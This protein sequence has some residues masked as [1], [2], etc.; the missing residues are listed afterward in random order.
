MSYV[1]HSSVAELPDPVR[2]SLDST[3]VIGTEMPSIVRL[4]QTGQLR[5]APNGGWQ[6]FTATQE[7]TLDPPGFVWRSKLK[8]GGLPLAKAT[9]SLIDGKGSMQVRVMGMITVVDEQGPEMDQG[10]VLRWFNETMWF[11]SIW[12]SPAIAWEQIDSRSAAGS[13]TV[14]DVKVTA[15][16]RFDEVGRLVDF[17][18]DRY[19]TVGD[20]FE[21]T[22]W[23]TPL[24]DH[25]RLAGLVLPAAGSGCPGRADGA[26]DD[27]GV[28]SPARRR[29]ARCDPRARFRARDQSG[30]GD[31]GRLHLRGSAVG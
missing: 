6:K 2:R 19:R 9:D 20:E 7:Y 28:Q 29:T 15:E 13:I 11:P 5:M 30:L 8:V 21:M 17:V 27:A 16:F 10:S 31:H 23:S 18:A 4:R 24:T 3:G 12:A 14:G 25:R 22:S 26:V 1:T